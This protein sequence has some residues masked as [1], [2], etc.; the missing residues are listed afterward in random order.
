[1]NDIEQLYCRTNLLG[2]IVIISLMT[3]CRGPI[4]TVARTAGSSYIS[5]LTQRITKK[6][7]KL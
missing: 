5:F 2:P 7:P 1:M 3:F 4:H 6:F